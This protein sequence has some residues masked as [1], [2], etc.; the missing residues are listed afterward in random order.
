MERVDDDVRR[1]LVVSQKVGCPNS[2]HVGAGSPP[3][4]DARLGVFHHDTSGWRHGEQSHRGQIRLGIRFP[5]AVVLGPEQDP[6]IAE[7]PQTLNRL[8]HFNPAG[9]RNHGQVRAPAKA[10][11]GFARPRQRLVSLVREESPLLVHRT[12][13]ELVHAHLQPMVA[14][15]HGVDLIPRVADHEMLL[16]A[17]NLDVPTPQGQNDRLHVVTLGVDQGSVEIEEKCGAEGHGSAKDYTEVRWHAT[18]LFARRSLVGRKDSTRSAPPSVKDLLR[19]NADLRHELARLESY[20]VLAYRDELTGL[21]NR[22][23]FTER[24]TEELSRAHRQPRRHFGIMMVDVNSLK[25]INDAH[26]R[27]EGDLVLRWVAELLE[28]SLRAHDVIC[29]VGDDEFAVLFPEVGVSGSEPLLARLHAAL[30][31]TRTGAPFSIGLSFGFADY[32]E[33]GT[34]CN[35]LMRV[36]DHKMCLDKRR[37]SLASAD[38]TIPWRPRAAVR[39]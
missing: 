37:Q 9:T 34:T 30:S 12:R 36:A 1:R 3:R 39:T 21:W 18:Y 25:S 17:V 26:S 5:L 6:K 38:P 23:Y 16:G 8:V 27:E 13:D 7:H 11:D 19:E 22:R 28:R 15:N 31:E 32:P 35:Q 24:L 4:Q 2:D 20:R 29:R 33:D 10:L 14:A